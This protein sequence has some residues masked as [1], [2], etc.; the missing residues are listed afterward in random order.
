MI[1]PHRNR[2]TPTQVALYQAEVARRNKEG[3][4]P[5]EQ[6]T[7]L[8][9]LGE[10]PATG[11]SVS[12]ISSGVTRFWRATIRGYAEIN[13]VELGDF[14]SGPPAL[15]EFLLSLFGP[16]DRV[17]SMLGDLEER[18]HSDLETVSAKRARWRYRGRVWRSLGPLIFNKLRSLGFFAFVLEVCRRKFGW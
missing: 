1:P 4:P 17:E 8:G 7:F 16:K 5:G 14:R 12:D 9:Q 6:P 15:S 13:R 3:V 10:E 2:M 18:F 11:P